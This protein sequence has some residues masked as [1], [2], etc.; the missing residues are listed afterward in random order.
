[1]ESVNEMVVDMQYTLKLVKKNML[2][3]Q[4]CAKFCVDKDRTLQ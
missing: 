2:S 3:A 1:M 4:E